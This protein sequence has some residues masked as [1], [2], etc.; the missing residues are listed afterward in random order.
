[1]ALK[2]IFVINGREDRRTVIDADLER[3]LAGVELNYDVYHTTGVGDGIRFVRIYC[4]LHRDEEVCFVAC[5]GSG[6]LNEVA[7][8]IVGFQHK[9]L[10]ILA[11]GSTNDFIK[12]YPDRDFK[13]LK[14]ILAG[15]ETKVDIIKANN[16][17]S[18]NVINVGFD[19]SVASL[20]NV[21]ISKGMDG[22]KAYR[23]SVFTS[24]LT[25][26]F[27]NIQIV[28]DGK[29]LNKRK[30][31]L[32]TLSNARWCGGQ[33]L[34]APRADVNDGLMD[35]CLFKTCSIFA[36]LV[37][38]VNYEKGAHLDDKFC[39]RRIKYCRAKRVEIHSKDLI[40]ICVDGETIADIDFEVELLPD[41]I[42]LVLPAQTEE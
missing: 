34:C 14:K 3:Q 38:M 17:Y 16:N 24:L 7:S 36:F 25:K 31:L 37:M 18:L 29:L 6:T 41:A 26:R 27:N 28:A 13:S 40:Y 35:V 1:M 10:A 9:S 2:Y 23:Q 30:M 33:Y 32:C 15:E 21:K 5:G 4:D 12:Y 19:A 22:V 8:G 42:N 20:G 11:Y 39:K